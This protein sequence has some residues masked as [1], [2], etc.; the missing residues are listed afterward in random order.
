MV[1]YCGSEYS[2]FTILICPDT[3]LRFLGDPVVPIREDS[4]TEYALHIVKLPLW[5]GP[6]IRKI[7]KNRVFLL[8]LSLGYS[9]LPFGTVSLGIG[10]KKLRPAIFLLA[11]CRLHA[12]VIRMHG[13]MESNGWFARFVDGNK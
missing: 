2:G 8:P 3:G 6:T 12:P 9:D 13:A 4:G 10:A 7:F 5:S 1:A 11:F